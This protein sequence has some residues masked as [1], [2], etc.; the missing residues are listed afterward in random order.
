MTRADG[1]MVL[2]PPAIQAKGVRWKEHIGRVLEVRFEWH[3]ARTTIV[4]VYQHVWSPAKTVQANR[5]NRASVFEPMCQA[6]SS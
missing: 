1:V 4:A 2:L 6:G 3:G 5:Q